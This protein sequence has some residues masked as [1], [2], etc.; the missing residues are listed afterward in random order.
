MTSGT[1]V[2]SG[3]VPTTIVISV[4]TDWVVLAG[5]MV[6]VTRSFCSGV[7]APGVRV[8][9]SNPASLSLPSASSGLKFATSGT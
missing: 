3:P 2:L 6:L 1:C 8:M 9:F 7:D 4:V 5:G